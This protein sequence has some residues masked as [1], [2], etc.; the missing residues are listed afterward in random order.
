VRPRHICVLPLQSWAFDGVGKRRSLNDKPDDNDIPGWHCSVEN[1]STE[2]D[3]HTCCP[4]NGP[5][6]LVL[7]ILRRLLPESPLVVR[8]IFPQLADDTGYLI[9][10]SHSVF[11]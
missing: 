10:P 8:Q 9:T 1:F 5:L 2:N 4:L 11:S 7:F 3:T 6:V